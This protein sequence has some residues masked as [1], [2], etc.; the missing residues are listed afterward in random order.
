MTRSALFFACAFY[1]GAVLWACSSSS[2]PANPE[3]GVFFPVPS[4]VTGLPDTC[5]PSGQ[6]VSSTD[7][8]V[9]VPAGL[10]D[11]GAVWFLC[12]VNEYRWYACT[13][14][15]DFCAGYFCPSEE[16]GADGGDGGDAASAASDG[17]LDEAG[18]RATDSGAGEVDD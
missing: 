16:L 1:G 7:A 6:T 12:D 11:G 2:S 18:D 17:G 10:C 3:P 15:A 13:D 9:T 14:P 5:A 4:S 8:G